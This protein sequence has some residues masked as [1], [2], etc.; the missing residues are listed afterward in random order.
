MA[1]VLEE[2]EAH[3]SDGAGE[4]GEAVEILTVAV[5]T[6]DPPDGANAAL[7]GAE[8]PG[9]VVL[10]V[11]D[12]G[13][14]TES[15]SASNRRPRLS[16]SFPRPVPI[17]RLPRGQGGGKGFDPSSARF[18]ALFTLPGLGAGHADSARSDEDRA[19]RA[20]L[21]ERFVRCLLA[22]GGRPAEFTMYERL[23]M[24]ARFTCA[25]V[26]FSSVAVHDLETP[27]GKQP[28]ALLRASDVIVFQVQLADSE[29]AV[30]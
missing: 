27:L 5:R 21:R 10:M 3:G 26:P 20:T 16:C 11:R 1:G 23:R 29:A 28:A 7:G 8:E 14:A 17:L 6:E 4:G 12:G 2:N 19:V 22:L 18:K 25:D 24:R 9:R 13:C 15:E 30:G